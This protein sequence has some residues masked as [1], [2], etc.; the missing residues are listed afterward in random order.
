MMVVYDWEQVYKVRQEGM[1][2][3]KIDVIVNSDVKFL[4]I[5]IVGFKCEGVEF[6]SI[7]LCCKMN[8]FSWVFRKQ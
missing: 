6:E 2:G 7:C 4:E 1:V 8:C 3:D 5:F